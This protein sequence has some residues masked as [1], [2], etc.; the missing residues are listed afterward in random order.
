[1]WSYFKITVWANIWLTLWFVIF[2]FKR[3]G[4]DNCLSWAMKKYDKEGGY[5]V[6]RFSR[7]NRV[8]WLK[9]P[10]FLWLDSKYEKNLKH[11]VPIE[12]EHAE[13]TIPHPWFN[14]RV[15]QGDTDENKTDEN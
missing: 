8:R 6:I 5:L 12:D 13:K 15:K 11:Y 7:S 3:K 2:A 10:H 4:R 9:W 1:M 14:G